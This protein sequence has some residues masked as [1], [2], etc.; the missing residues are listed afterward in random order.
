VPS[1]RQYLAALGAAGT[2]VGAAGVTKVVTV[3]HLSPA[4]ERWRTAVGA[5]GRSA[6]LVDGRLFLT[7]EGDL[8]ALDAATGERLWSRRLDGRA[9]YGV[10]AGDET[11]YAGDRELAAV[12]PDGTVRWRRRLTAV[13]PDARD[14]ESLVAR[15]VVSPDR[16]FAAT[17]SG[18]VLAFDPADG[19]VAWTTALDGLVGSLALGGGRLVA[20]A[21]DEGSVVAAL[22]PTTG[23]E[24][25]RRSFDA[26][27]R[28]LA[29]GAG[30]AVLSLSADGEG[31]VVG[32]D[33][34]T[35]A[36]RWGAD[37][38]ATALTVS[39]GTV[40]G[41]AGEHPF[42]ATGS[43]P[44]GRLFARDVATGDRLWAR[45][46]RASGRRPPTRAG[47]T[48]LV[49]SVLDAGDRLG[50]GALAA[51]T[52]AGEGRFTHALGPDDHPVASPVVGDAVYVV[53]DEDAVAVRTRGAR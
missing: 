35:G 1:R 38:A 46:T 28:G 11:V 31:R 4:W 53:T 13:V 8:D 5:V 47:E 40:Y 12:A 23:D 30:R 29:T 32:L 33:G 44:H 2:L 17:G 48:L 26:V 42:G 6:A 19:S 45:E 34:T 51:Y 3:P 43:G 39:D 18:V 52:T 20:V 21:D 27:P 37:R 36:D 41:V 7:S 49:S 24:R 50:G 9:L 10:V 25:W 14:R 22:D 15:P 16:V